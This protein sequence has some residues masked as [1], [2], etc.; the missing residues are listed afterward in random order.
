MD[1]TTKQAIANALK[2]LGI[3]PETG[4]VTGRA[5]P[6]AIE[7]ATA[8]AS[9]L[10]ANGYTDAANALRSYAA[11]AANNVE[12]ET[13]AP[14][15]PLP[16]SL[17]RELVRA[18]SLEGDPKRI[19]ALVERVKKSK[20]GSNP[21]ILATLAA[22]EARA[23]QLEKE[24]DAARTAQEVED[25]IKMPDD[26]TLPPPRTPISLPAPVSP[27]SLPTPTTAPATYTVKSGDF[28]FKIAEMFTGDG[29]RW[30]ELQAANPDKPS[31]L[32][33]FLA[34]WVLKLPE[35]WGGGGS[36][37]AP[38]PT[39]APSGVTVPTSLPVPAPAPSAAPRT[40][41]VKSGDYPFKIAEMFTG[42]GNR[43]KELQAANPDKPSFL[44][45]F[46]AG[47]VLKLPESW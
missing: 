47:W 36:S 18:L 19:R 5:T 17:S 34:G 16:E 11:Q 7:S 40:Y 38:V 1:T 20:W 32:K 10:E 15:Q 42:D 41:T 2:G 35:S 6:D 13:P 9:L 8:L 3:D 14:L 25:L 43:W 39:P 37:P 21:Q 31:F 22:L 26:F 30:K 12:V 46:Y 45:K 28:P 23:T 33:T 29:N 24:Q 44:K 4:A 27:V